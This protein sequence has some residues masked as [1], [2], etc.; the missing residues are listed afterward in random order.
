MNSLYELDSKWKKLLTRDN[1]LGGLT[2][3]E[4]VEQLGKDHTLRVPTKGLVSNP[5]NIND[6]GYGAVGTWDPKPYVRTFES[7]L[8][9]LAKLQHESEAIK[10]KLGSE[11]LE[12]E[13]KHSYAIK[14]LQ[15]RLNEITTEYVSLDSKLASVTKGVKPLGDKLEKSIRQKKQYTKSVELVNI[16]NEFLETNDSSPTLAALLK[17]PHFGNQLNA[18]AIMKS[19]IALAKKIETQSIPKTIDATKRIESIAESME[20]K[21]LE[22]FNHAYRDSDFTKLNE[23]AIILNKF[24]AGVNVISNFINQHEFFVEQNQFDINDENGT[25]KFDFDQNLLN[26]DYHYVIY[27]KKVMIPLLSEIASVIEK[28]SRIVIQVFDKKAIQVLQLFIQRIFV[29]KLEPKINHILVNSLNWSNLLYIRNLHSLHSLMGQFIKDLSTFFQDGLISNGNG[30]IIS[31]LEQCYS[32][33]F[34]NYLYDRSRYFDLEKQNLESIL[35]GKAKKLN[36]SFSKEITPRALNIKLNKMIEN[37]EDMTDFMNI[38]E[39]GVSNDIINGVGSHNKNMNLGHKFFNDGIFNNKLSQYKNV[40]KRRLDFDNSTIKDTG[41]DKVPESLSL[42]SKDQFE[43]FDLENVDAMLKCVVEAVAR[44]MELIPNKASEYTLELLEVMF[45]GIIGS[46][47]DSGLEIAYYK[48]INSDT[49]YDS[50]DLLSLDYISKSTEMLNYLSISIKSVFLPLLKNSPKN[51][52]LIIELTNINIKKSEISINIIMAKLV[53]MI[54]E[55]F[56]TSLAKQTRK[57]FIPKTQDLID[58]DTVPAIEIVNFL[59][60]IH[61]QANNFLKPKN[62]N[63]FLIKIGEILYNM[64]LVHYSKFPVNSIGGIIV[65]KDIIGYLNIIELWNIQ[66]LVDKFSTLRELAN[67]F[68]VKSDLLESLTMEGHLLDVDSKIINAYIANRQDSISDNFISTVKN[69]I[70]QYT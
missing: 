64:L 31:T 53:D 46:Y 9:E 58:H 70:K 61:S 57:D 22:E 68:T 4:F 6:H 10:S 30:E 56:S 24:N 25:E 23:I 12:Q 60:K 51:K 15:S 55:C 67:L 37:G 11:V 42:S 14:E 62:L 32:D 20:N 21:W 35:I 16:Y 65:T 1:L 3:N 33:L 63:K 19:L 48:L 49:N 43:L 36:T 40:I 69:N 44:I 54:T 45:I 50:L 39:I 28:E 34:S 13:L 52:Q 8:K 7:I 29:Q 59:N 17:S 38:N 18:A 41:E 27:D 47:I 66:Y 26:P 5:S 2:V